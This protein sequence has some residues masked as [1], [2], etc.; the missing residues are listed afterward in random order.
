VPHGLIAAT[1]RPRDVA[2]RPSSC[3]AA[4]NNGKLAKIVRDSTSLAR[5][6]LLPGAAACLYTFAVSSLYTSFPSSCL[7]THALPKL[8]FGSI[9]HRAAHRD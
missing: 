8:C 1:V 4:A 2:E 7:G 5:P 3:S 9:T 6:E